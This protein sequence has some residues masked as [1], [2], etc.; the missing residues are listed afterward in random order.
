[1]GTGVSLHHPPW[2][3]SRGT[4]AARPS[5]ARTQALNACREIGDLAQ[6]GRSYQRNGPRRLK[7]Q[8]QWQR[9]RC[10]LGGKG[11]SPACTWTL[12]DGPTAVSGSGLWGVGT[13][14]K[15]QRALQTARGGHVVTVVGSGRVCPSH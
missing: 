3:L 15:G 4:R 5:L 9:G 6:E 14:C 2:A 12:G 10:H 7:L 1:M 11:P 8:V 13:E